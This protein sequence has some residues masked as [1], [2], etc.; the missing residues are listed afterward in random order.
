MKWAEFSIHTTH[1]AVE[2]I[3]NILHEAGAGGVII[4]EPEGIEKTW[5]HLEIEK[6]FFPENFPKEEICIKAYYPVNSHLME[7]IEQIKLEINNLIIYQINIGKGSILISEVHEDDWATTWKQYYKPM[8]VSTKFLVVPA[9]EK[10][11]PE[12]NQLI[13]ELDPGMA[14]G[15]GT[16]PTTVMCIE[17][18]EKVI[19]GNEEII[20]VGCGTGVLSIAAAKLGAKNILALDLDD[21]ALESAERNIILNNVQS[22]VKVQRNNLL[23]GINNKADIIVANI[24]AEVILQFTSDVA[25]V[26]KHNGIFITSGII[27]TKEQIVKESLEKEGLMVIETLYKEEWVAL[28]AKKV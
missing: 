23:N 16:H 12:N 13:I 28:I 20:D 15:T 22:M 6:D 27:Q 19:K 5:E 14:F 18:L 26:L 8:K 1:E 17:S 24:L 21:I 10:I 9:W 11:A 2:S 7:T 4:E 25:R 3:A